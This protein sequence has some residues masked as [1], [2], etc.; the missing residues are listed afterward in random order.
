MTIIAAS[1]F[2]SREDP[3]IEE[4]IAITI[5]HAPTIL[6][7][8]VDKIAKIVP[9]YGNPVM[10]CDMAATEMAQMMRMSFEKYGLP[11]YSVPERAGRTLWALS[12]GTY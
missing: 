2:P 3:A 9:K 12:Y 5:H 1:A 10:V 8:S 4:L 6:D 11:S 7:D